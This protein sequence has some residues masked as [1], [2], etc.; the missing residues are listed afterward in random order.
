MVHPAAD[1]EQLIEASRDGPEEVECS[2]RDMKLYRPKNHPYSSLF[3]PLYED[4]QVD[5]QAL[6]DPIQQLLI[7]A[8][9]KAGASYSQSHSGFRKD[10]CLQ[11]RAVRYVRTHARKYTDSLC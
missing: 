10:H 1:R 5:T 4:P 7:S 6:S 9:S 3:T 8:I 2:H 11:Q